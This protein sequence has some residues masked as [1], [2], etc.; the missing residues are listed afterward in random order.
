MYIHTYRETIKTFSINPDYIEQEFISADSD[1]SI[2]SEH[3]YTN[4]PN[5]QFVTPFKISPQPLHHHD[6]IYDQLHNETTA[7]TTHHSGHFRHKTAEIWDP[8]PEYE[9]VAFG[10]KL[11]LILELNDDIPKNIHVS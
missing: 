1:V 7:E 6:L 11:H 10:K 8:H 5:V 4:N 2:S 3:H 9:I